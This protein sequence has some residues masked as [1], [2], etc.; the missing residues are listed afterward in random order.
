MTYYFLPN[1]PKKGIFWW[2]Y[3][4][5]QEQ[6]QILNVTVDTSIWNIYQKK[7]MF[8]FSLRLKVQIFKISSHCIKQYISITYQLL[9]LSKNSTKNSF[10][11][12]LVC[13][14]SP[15]FSTSR[16]GT[17][18]VTPLWWPATRGILGSI[19]CTREERT[20]RNF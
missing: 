2:W 20:V 15:I 8:P 19:I 11:S 14:C 16:G 18:I 1:E 5:V 17:G 6:I 10:S 3:T 4:L 9:L 12:D 13:I 7:I